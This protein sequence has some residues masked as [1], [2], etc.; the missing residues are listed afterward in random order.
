VLLTVRSHPSYEKEMLADPGTS[1]N[2]LYIYKKDGK[3][4]RDKLTIGH[5]YTASGVRSVT[6]AQSL[7]QQ[8]KN[9]N[10]STK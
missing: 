9:K 3:V 2:L 8:I 7:M 6:K 4:K 5:Y 1:P 10:I